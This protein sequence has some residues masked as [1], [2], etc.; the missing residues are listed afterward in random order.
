MA[1]AEQVKRF[2]ISYINW[3]GDEVRSEYFTGTDRELCKYADGRCN[4]GESWLFSELK[5]VTKED[6]RAAEKVLDELQYA[7]GREAQ[8]K[9]EAELERLSKDFDLFRWYDRENLRW[10]ALPKGLH[11]DWVAVTCYGER[12]RWYS[13]EN[14]LVFY[15]DASLACEGCERERYENVFFG[16]YDGLSEVTDGMEW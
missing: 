6:C 13:R 15:H 7:N 1:R 14:A 9:Y 3:N 4:D 16:L 8:G 10:M 2:E 5:A 12:E 11:R